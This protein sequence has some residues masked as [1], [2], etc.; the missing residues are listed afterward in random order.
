MSRGRLV[1]LIDVYRDAHGQPA[2]ASIARAIGVA[3]Q[4]L[5]A[6][7]KRGIR[8]LPDRDTLRRLAV[9]IGV[10]LRVV[11]EAALVDAGY[12]TE[13]DM[14]PPPESNGP[15]TEGRKGA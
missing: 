5:N 11:I 9:F 8:N 4:T 3:P 14:T 15:P 1:A 12:M 6:W 13:A 7:R 10:P 2:D